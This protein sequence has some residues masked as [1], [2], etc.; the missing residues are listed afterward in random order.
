MPFS[1]WLTAGRISLERNDCHH[2]PPPARRIALDPATDG[3]HRPPPPEVLPREAE[4][5]AVGVE[6]GPADQVRLP[7]RVV[8]HHKGG[9]VADDDQPVDGPSGS[10]DEAAVDGAAGHRDATGDLLLDQLKV[11]CLH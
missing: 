6:G 8:P 1:R 9:R 7:P 10:I 4:P 3:L 11:G 5:L 2:R